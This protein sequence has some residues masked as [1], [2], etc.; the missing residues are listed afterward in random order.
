MEADGYLEEN[1]LQI[2]CPNGRLIAVGWS[3]DQEVFCTKVIENCNWE[4]PCYQ[5][6][7]SKKEWMEHDVQMFIDY[8]TAE[9]SE[10]ISKLFDELKLM[11]ESL[12]VQTSAD[13]NQG[14]E[15]LGKLFD[16]GIDQ[17]DIEKH[18]GIYALRFRDD[19]DEIRWN[20]SCDLLDMINVSVWCVSE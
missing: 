10:T 15:I 5:L 13:F 6:H 20:F 2:Q 18:L 12:R 1:L 3:G 19:Y 4:K 9:F 8:E 7:K 11:I 16:A 17:G 14:C